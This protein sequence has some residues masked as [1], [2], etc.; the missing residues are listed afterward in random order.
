M[1]VKIISPS[2]C[3]VAEWK[4]EIDTKL[5]SGGALS[6]RI[7]ET[8]FVLFNPWCLQDQV[9][10]SDEEQRYEYVMEQ[11]GLIWRGTA[12]RL[13]P[14]PW[15]YAQFERDVL[16]CA[17]YVVSKVGKVGSRARGDPVRMVRALSA[18]VNSPDD[19]GVVYGN[20]GTD[21]GK[22]TAPT[23]WV[24]SMKILQE[25]LKT[26]KPVK[27]GQCWVFSGVLGTSK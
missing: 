1:R 25:Y 7:P 5:Y 15:V 23:K 19:N 16:E 21:F 17:M 13:R 24:G 4:L 2:K 18:A 8:I 9:Y 27:Y 22:H 3:P 6:Y 11:Q 10:L 12:Q 14:V 26:K 20:W